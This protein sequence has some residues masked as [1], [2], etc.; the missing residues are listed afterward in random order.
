M[1]YEL[2]ILAS[3]LFLILTKIKKSY[4]YTFVKMY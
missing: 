2:R 1:G 3:T 4:V